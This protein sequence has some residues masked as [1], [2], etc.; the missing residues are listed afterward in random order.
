MMIKIKRCRS[1]LHNQVFLKKVKQEE[2]EEVEEE[3]KLC[4]NKKTQKLKNQ[5]KML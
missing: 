2:V 3:D 5:R 4:R 1:K